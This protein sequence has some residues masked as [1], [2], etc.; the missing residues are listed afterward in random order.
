MSR[1]RVHMANIFVQHERK[2]TRCS[3]K[4]CAKGTTIIYYG[5][6]DTFYVLFDFDCIIPRSSKMSIAD[7]L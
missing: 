6:V 3:K 4:A 5:I 1:K 2:K 7:D